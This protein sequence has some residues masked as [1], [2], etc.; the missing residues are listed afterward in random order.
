[1]LPVSLQAHPTISAS[2]WVWR[3]VARILHCHPS[4]HP[5]ASIWNNSKIL[6]GGRPLLWTD[7]IIAGVLCLRDLFEGE[8]M[9]SFS[10]LQEKFALSSKQ[11]W[12][13]LQLR[14]SVQSVLRKYPEALH[15]HSLSVT[16][17]VG[18]RSGHL[19]SRVYKLLIDPGMGVC[20]PLQSAWEGDLN[21]EWQTIWN[22]CT[23]ASVELKSRLTQFKILHRTYRTP[24]RLFKAG[25]VSDSLC[26]KC[27][28]ENGSLLHML[29]SCPRITCLWRG[30]FDRY[31]LVLGVDIPFS[32]DI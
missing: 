15:S 31:S 17:Q 14:S 32:P 3:E 18:F 7:W 9:R 16:F 21:Y 27:R 5:L 4:V 6:V 30:V 25:L 19:A 2:H 22:N 11:F 26:W 10:Q 13:F 29:L 1:R 28:S 23:K 20:L 12:R 8:V 24:L